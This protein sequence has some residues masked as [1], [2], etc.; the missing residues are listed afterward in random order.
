VPLYLTEQ[1]VDA[2]LTPE[3]AVEAVEGSFRRTAEG[4]VENVPRRRLGLDGG[5]LAVM[6]AVDLGLGVAGVKTYAWTRRTATRRW[7]S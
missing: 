5:A 6:S 3:D 2:L 4:L 7:H 1:D